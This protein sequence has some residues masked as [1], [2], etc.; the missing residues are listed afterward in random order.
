LTPRLA[1]YLPREIA[2]NSALAFAPTRWALESRNRRRG[3]DSEKNDASYALGV[4]E[5]H[6]R[7]IGEIR[8]RALEIGPGGNLAVA[9]LF[10][11]HGAERSV[12][13]D[14]VPW[15]Q[16]VGTL[17]EDLG[18][19]LDRVEYVTP[20]AIEHAPFPDESFEIVFSQASFEHFADPATAVKEISRILRPGGVTTHEI[21][22]R[23]HR[24]FDRPLDFLTASDRIYRLA[25]SRR[26]GQ[27]NRWRASDFEE[28]FAGAGLEVVIEPMLQIEVPAERAS[29]L[30]PRFRGK[31][32]SDLGILTMFLTARK[33]L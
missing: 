15:V 17:Y 2:K 24:D 26:A 20:A 31:S 22:L 5:R 16:D 4:F 21:D 30:A 8:G 13:M 29:S 25:T 33:P 7:A 9:A 14:I 27:P 19:D 11:K 23:D 28:A 1:R 10:V 3:Y 18:V 6:R 32:L 12:A